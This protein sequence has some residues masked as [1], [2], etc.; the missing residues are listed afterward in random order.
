MKEG[1]RED[2][3]RQRGEDVEKERGGK[4]GKREGGNSEF[5]CLHFSN[6]T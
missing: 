6:T 1:E 3:E 5:V 4:K 2:G